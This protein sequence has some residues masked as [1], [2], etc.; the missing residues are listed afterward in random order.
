MNSSETVKLEFSPDEENG[1]RIVNTLSLSGIVCDIR[2]IHHGPTVTLYEL[3]LDARKKVSSVL[4]LDDKL[5]MVLEVED[6]RI[7]APIPGKNAIG[8]EVPNK[9]RTVV[10][11]ES[12][13]DSLE[14]KEGRKIPV[15]LGMDVYGDPLVIDLTC[16]PHLLIGGSEGSGKTTFIDSLICS[17]LSTRTPDDVRLILVDTKEVELSVY[18]GIPHLLAPVITDA[19]K[20]MKAL[21]YIVSELERRIRL[22]TE[23]GVRKIEEYNGKVAVNSGVGKLPY[24]VVIIDDYADLILTA[25]KEFESLI[26][27]ITTSAKLCGIHLVISTKRVSPGVVTGVV[28]SNFP[29]Q[30]AFAVQSGINSRILIDQTGAEKLLGS[31]DMFYNSHMSRFLFRIQGAMIDSGVEK[32]IGYMK[33]MG[34]P[35]YLD[36]LCFEETEYENS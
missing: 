34:R 6:V 9:E 1:R 19:G 3:S 23:A 29:S 32:Y 33:K 20:A 12:M 15:V 22:L 5:A 35:D 30:I 8:V 28:K 7:I 24:I 14:S 11:F 10:G 16:C 18:N 4:S 36:E 2:A 13:L 31:G 17:I 25:G 21:G 26:K 27:R